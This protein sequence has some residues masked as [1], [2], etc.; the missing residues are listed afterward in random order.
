MEQKDIECI[1]T[2]LEGEKPLSRGCWQR[3]LPWYA[4][5]S[6]FFLI[7]IVVAFF[8]AYYVSQLIIELKI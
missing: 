4:L 1:N 6:L 7:C 8:I 2:A 3:V 5:I